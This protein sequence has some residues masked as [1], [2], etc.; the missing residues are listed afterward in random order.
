MKVQRKATKRPVRKY[1][2]CTFLKCPKQAQGATRN[3]GAIGLC[4]GHGGNPCKKLNPFWPL[5]AL[6]PK[7]WQ[8]LKIQLC[9]QNCGNAAKPFD[10]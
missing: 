8:R 5:K 6:R 7:L 10:R 3:K 4:K 9:G 2:L 1:K